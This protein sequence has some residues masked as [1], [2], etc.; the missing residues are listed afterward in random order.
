MDIGDYRNPFLGQK[1]KRVIVV[2]ITPRDTGG[3]AKMGT[4]PRELG[5]PHTMKQRLEQGSG[6]AKRE[7]TRAEGI[8]SPQAKVPHKGHDGGEGD[9]G[10]RA[11]ER[12]EN[13][14]KSK[15]GPPTMSRVYR[16]RAKTVMS[17]RKLPTPEQQHSYA[18]KNTNTR[19]KIPPSNLRGRVSLLS[20]IKKKKKR[21]GSCF[22]QV[23]RG[24]RYKPGKRKGREP[25][26]SL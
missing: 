8:H 25:I 7:H 1:K 6:A 23:P 2:Y 3:E 22:R 14:V 4:Q 9:A 10:K 16:R 15:R 26:P 17:D 12:K 24:G 21:R 18:S 11:D 20:T 5:A 13:P 19:T